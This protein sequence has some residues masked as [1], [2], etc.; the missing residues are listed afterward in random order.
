MKQDYYKSKKILIVDDEPDLLELVS[1]TLMESGYLYV[2]TAESAKE[3][4]EKLLENPPDAAIL[5]VMLPDGNGFDLCREIRGERNIPVLFLS[6]RGEAEDRVQGLGLGADDY[7]TKPFL[8]K[9]LVLRLDAVLRR[10]YQEENPTI[11]IE[12]GEV[13]LD[14]AIVRNEGKEIPLTAKECAILEVLY[15]N[16]GRIVTVD[17]LCQAVWGDNYFGYESPLMAHIRRIREKIEK[18]PSA[19]V[20]LLTVKGLGYKLI[21]KEGR[22]WNK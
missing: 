14:R 7:I 1:V 21:A 15:R 4:R 16:A 17:G 18:N 9:E 11:P 12:T 20:T 22:P 3:A 8:P 2:D 19:P 5:D 10:S 6:A 13:D